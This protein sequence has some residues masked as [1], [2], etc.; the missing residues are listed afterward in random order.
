M[1]N[2]LS[3]QT[4][5]GLPV[6]ETY[7]VVETKLRNGKIIKQLFQRV[8]TA[9]GVEDWQLVDEKIKAFNERF[10]DTTT[11]P[12]NWKAPST[13]VLTAKDRET[14]HTVQ[15]GG[16]TRIDMRRQLTLGLGDPDRII[17]AKGLDEARVKFFKAHPSTLTL[18]HMMAVKHGD[19]TEVKTDG[20]RVK[21]FWGT[22]ASFI[23]S[24]FP[25]SLP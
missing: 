14:V 23:T 17:Q 9:E 10:G 25:D 6:E 20:R 21:H 22:V 1:T 13:E 11:I 18:L 24:P 7:D 15:Q 3:T 8:I 5:L 12:A 16:M 2:P 19:Y 4:V